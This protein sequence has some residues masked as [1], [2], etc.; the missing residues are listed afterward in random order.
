MLEDSSLHSATKDYLQFNEGDRYDLIIGLNE[1]K[2]GKM[3]NIKFTTDVMVAV[4]PK[5]F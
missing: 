4:K 2:E 5:P 3:L 1:E